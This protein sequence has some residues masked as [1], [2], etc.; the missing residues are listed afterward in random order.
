MQTSG[1]LGTNSSTLDTSSSSESRPTMDL[2][3]SAFSVNVRPS[4]L[5]TFRRKPAQQLTA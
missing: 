5:F 3:L 4:G 2:S 1:T